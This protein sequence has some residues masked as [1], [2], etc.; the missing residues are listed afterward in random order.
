MDAE[1]KLQRDIHP[2]HREAVTSE[3]TDMNIT[4]IMEYLNT[5]DRFCVANDMKITVLAEGYAEAEMPISENKLNGLDV[6]QGGAIYTLAD[7]AFAGASNANREDRRCIGSATSINYI[8][9]GTGTKLK[10]VAKI[11]HAGKKTCLSN[12]EVFND[13]GKL[14]ATANFQGFMLEP[15]GNKSV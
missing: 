14:I 12:V 2:A 13:Q 10:A 3:R 1:E 9:P 7:F 4:E 11:I 6:V 15:Q 8:R 5:K